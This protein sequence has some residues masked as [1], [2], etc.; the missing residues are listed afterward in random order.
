MAAL[1]APRQPALPPVRNATLASCR[2]GFCGNLN[3]AHPCLR[4]DPDDR[5]HPYD[6]QQ[7]LFL[8]VIARVAALQDVGARLRRA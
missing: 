7:E 1:A 5:S 8:M 6:L 2:A 4:L 3:A